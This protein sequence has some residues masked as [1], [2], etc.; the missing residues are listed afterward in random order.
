[1]RSSSSMSDNT[2][3]G[4]LAEEDRTPAERGLRGALAPDA[5]FRS[6][7]SD[8]RHASSASERFQGWLQ[9]GWLRAAISGVASR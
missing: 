6:L 2:M 7:A 5:R 3:S 1:M 8:H 4:S 9:W